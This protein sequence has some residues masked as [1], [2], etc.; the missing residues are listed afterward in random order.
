VVRGTATS[1][2]GIN[3]ST[4]AGLMGQDGNQGKTD[5]MINFGRNT[6]YNPRPKTDIF[7]LF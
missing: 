4:V 1:G 6:L 5:S 3:K 2:G 7:E